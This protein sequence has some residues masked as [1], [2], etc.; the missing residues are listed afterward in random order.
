M[1]QRG[2]A[3]IFSRKS[4]FSLIIRIEKVTITRDPEFVPK[5]LSPFKVANLLPNTITTPN[6]YMIQGWMLIQ[7]M[8][9]VTMCHCR[10]IK[11]NKRTAPLEDADNEWDRVHGKSLTCSVKLYYII[12]PLLKEWSQYTLKPLFFTIQV[13]S[14]ICTFY[15]FKGKNRH[16]LC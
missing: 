13:E 5:M 7:T 3:N 14:T 4:F 9:W 15:G 6:V 16:E 10:F 1:G 12:K 8:D 2:L 11:C